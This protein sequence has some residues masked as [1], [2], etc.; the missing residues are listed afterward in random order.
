MFKQVDDLNQA[1]KEDE[2]RRKADEQLMKE[3]EEEEALL[4]REERQELI[5]DTLAGNLNQLKTPTELPGRKKSKDDE[6]KLSFITIKSSSDDEKSEAVDEW[7]RETQELNSSQFEIEEEEEEDGDF[8]FPERDLEY[9]I[10]DEKVKFIDYSDLDCLEFME[11]VVPLS[12]TRKIETGKNFV[13]IS[14]NIW[15]HHFVGVTSSEMV[16]YQFNGGKLD[17]NPIRS[18]ESKSKKLRENDFFSLLLTFFF[19][20]V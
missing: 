7:R 15:T 4:E 14:Y 1:I 16:L 19:S 6:L 12:Q 20:V 17:S 2:D 8:L 9:L 13:H 10:P 18:K 3:L 5:I 11:K